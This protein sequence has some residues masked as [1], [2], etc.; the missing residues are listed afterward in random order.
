MLSKFDK[1]ISIVLA[2]SPHFGNGFLSKFIRFETF[3]TALQ[4]FSYYLIGIP[5]MGVGRN[6]AIRRSTFIQNKGYANHIDLLSGNDDLYVN[7]NSNKSNTAIQLDPDTFVYTKAKENIKA[8]L[9]QKTRHISTST[10]YKKIH[11]VLL[12]LY[13]FSHIS[14]YISLII[15][16]FFLPLSTVFLIWAIR[17]FLIYVTSTKAFIKLRESDLLI[18]LPVLDFMMFIYY[19][20]IAFYYFFTSKNKWK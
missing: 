18:Y 16:L 1:N 10:R 5:Y 4:Y 17:I 6:M 2:Y 12:G 20:I 8:F 9:K 3:M 14:V 7:E 19:L 13:S 15:S 11:Q